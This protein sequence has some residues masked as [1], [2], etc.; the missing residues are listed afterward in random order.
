M[1]TPAPAT[2]VSFKGTVL[3]QLTYR[4]ANARCANFL[5]PPAIPVDELMFLEHMSR[6]DHLSALVCGIAPTPSSPKDYILELDVWVDGW[7]P[8]WCNQTQRIL[9]GTKMRYNTRM[10]SV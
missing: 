4:R 1:D 6:I 3:C 5:L 7:N 9:W 10:H 8:A 2:F